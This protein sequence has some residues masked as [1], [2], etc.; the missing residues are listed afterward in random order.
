MTLPELL[1]PAGD[2][3]TFV[4]AVNAGADAVYISGQSFGARAFAK[5]FTLEEIEK[6]VE[7][8]HLNG[9]KVHVTVNTLINNF[10]VVEV[11][12]YLFKL[13][14]MGVDA[15]IVQDLGIIELIENLIPDLEVHA[16]T[17]MT[18]SDYDCI[19]WAYDNNIS[20]VVLPRERNVDQ[21]SAMSA[22]MKEDNVKME[23]EVFGHG[24][25]CYCFSGNCYISSYNSGRS[26]NRGACAQP[27]RKLYKL[28]Y[29][30]YNVGN[31][32]LLSTHDLATYKGLNKI[33]DAGVFSLKLEGRMKSADYVGTIVNSYRNLID[34]KEGNFER[35]LHM[36]FNRQFT[37]GYILNQKPGQV[38]GRKSS[39]HEG[40][41]VGTITEQDGELIT[42]SKDNKEFPITLEIG[43][44]I[45]FKYKDKIKGIYIDNIKE[46]TD[47]YIKI[48][49][50]RK[51]RPGDKVF[52][53]YSKSTHDKLNQFKDE[54][55]SP[56]IP[57]SQ[58]R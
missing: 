24:A 26:G 32:F 5:N 45:G 33:E 30:N 53:S 6:A 49:T 8:A 40:V 54:S 57:L 51:V 21:I 55:V 42:I 18:L 50:T 12:N 7:Y 44:G 4:V 14:K 31:G 58:K 34:G 22:K 48:E 20:R 41:Y 3:E 16:S 23:L 19:L 46:Q 56:N 15:V 36:V 25:L 27:C 43:D 1:A 2:Y 38:L 52:I 28:K 11:V 13:Y 17:Q 29:K 37:D 47:D 39:G 9:A 35:D 10:E